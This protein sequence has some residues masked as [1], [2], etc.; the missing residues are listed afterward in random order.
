MTQSR[1]PIN[2][3][4]Y[5]ISKTNFGE[6]KYTHTNTKNILLWRKICHRIEKDQQTYES[7]CHYIKQDNTTK[8]IKGSLMT[9]RSYKHV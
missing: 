9:A 4:A 3:M 2:F 8:I 6:E 1:Q 7:S 5:Q